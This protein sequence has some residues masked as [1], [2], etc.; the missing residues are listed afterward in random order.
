M[1]EVTK[2][3]NIPSGTR[4]FNSRFVDE[5]KNAGTD[6]AFEKSRL[7]VQAYNDEEK[8]LVLTQSPTIQRVS[9]RLILILTA[10]KIND[11]NNVHLYLRDISQAYV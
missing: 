9:Q 4:L 6:A 7:V 8:K 2:L 10:M 11:N 3:E 1:F 5:V